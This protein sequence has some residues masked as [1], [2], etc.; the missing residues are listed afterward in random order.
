VSEQRNPRYFA[1][2][3]YATKFSEEPYPAAWYWH[4]ETYTWFGPYSSEEEARRALDAYERQHSLNRYQK[5]DAQ[6][7]LPRYR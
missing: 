1:S 6:R 7:M 2:S 5:L 4:D 3:W